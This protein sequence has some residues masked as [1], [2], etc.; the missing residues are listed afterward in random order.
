MLEKPRQNAVF[1]NSVALKW[2][3]AGR[4]CGLSGV[5]LLIEMGCQD[6]HFV[7][8]AL[9]D[10]RNH[11]KES[12][13]HFFRTDRRTSAARKTMVSTLASVFVLAALAGSPRAHATLP[14]AVD[15]QA[16][17]S[18]AP[19]LERV[20]PA[21]VNINSKTHVRVNNPFMND[22]FFRQFFGMQNMPRERVEQSLGSGVIID[23]GKGY[24]LTNNHVI[25]GADDISVT[26]HD[27]RSLKAKLIGSDPDTDVAVIQIP[28]EKLTAL[29]LADSNQL[30]VGDFVVALGNPFGVGQ[31]ATSGIVSGLN[32]TGLRGLG[33][34]NFIQ[35]DASINPGN[36]GGALV[37]LKGELVGINSAIY[38]PSG[39]NVGIGFAIPS[40]LAS[41]VMGQII[42]TGSVRHGSLGAQVQSV[43]AEIARMLGIKE[44]QQGA[45]VTQ[46]RDG[47]PAANAGLQT[48]DVI[49]AANGRPVQNEGDLYNAEG[50]AAIGSTI[51]LKLLREG[52]PVTVSARIEAERVASSEGAKLDA[53]LTGATLA[54]VSERTRAEGKSGVSVIS[55]APGSRAAEIG[56]KAGDI[57]FG[58]G[59]QRV[60]TLADLTQVLKRGLRQVQLVV[61]RGGDTFV[62]TL[63]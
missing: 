44:E 52:K 47:S 32:R 50:L 16:V 18:L 61:A 54:D 21:V 13:R 10:E 51:E 7:I 4:I 26:L 14:A 36:S 29:P 42:S 43:N 37:N 8:F 15:G 9:R 3:T 62:V 33:I 58:V 20:V 56:L 59:R 38:S 28:A 53:R 25:D 31:T 5:R 40:N 24:V 1:A 12:M 22:P 60:N 63:Q 19:M 49:V 2:G 41:N 11:S 46:V 45:V 17:P 48:G 27:G 30:R 6:G 57:I 34:Q 55:V 23:A 39:G 35:T